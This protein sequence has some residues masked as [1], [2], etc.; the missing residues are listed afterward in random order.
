M[1]I[2]EKL[3]ALGRLID[4]YSNGDGIHPTGVAGMRC[5][6]TSK[7]G[8][9]MP[10]IYNPSLCVIV[11]GRKQV[12]LE[13]E[14]YHYGPGQFLVVSVDL[15]L[16]GSVLE[17][18]DDQPYLCLQIDLDAKLLSELMTV[19]GTSKVVP[20]DTMRGLFVGDLDEATLDA[21][22]RLAGL[23]DTPRDIAMLAPVIQREIHYRMLSGTHGQ[24]IIQMAVSGSNM[25]KIA[26]VIRV[27]KANL[28][29]PL[30]IETLADMA[31]MSA[32]SF[33]HH[34][35]TV[36]ALSPLQYH[37]LLR[38]T[39]ARQIMF[40]EHADAASTAYRVGYESA[41]QFSR[42]YARMFGAPPLRDVVALRTEARRVD[43]TVPEQLH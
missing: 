42:E 35:K 37:K 36:T 17:A 21:V 12:L 14:I 15:P 27:M 31:H 23:L 39:E 26:E 11:Q 43:A 18:S 8:E 1:K 25:Q 9:G 24:A 19:S 40:A 28:A 16:L 32:S 2:T 34:F 4:K 7:P 6:K 29:L 41:S 3:S 10:A 13:Q 20:A 33:H 22:T 5:I 38:L 30:R